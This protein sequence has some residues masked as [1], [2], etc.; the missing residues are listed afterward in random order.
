V[1][2]CGISTSRSINAQVRP[3][4]CRHACC[5]HREFARICTQNMIEKGGIDRPK[6]GSGFEVAVVQI[7][8]ARLRRTRH[9]RLDPAERPGPWWP[10]H[11]CFLIIRI[12]GGLADGDHVPGRTSAPLPAGRRMIGRHGLA[13]CHRQ[14]LVCPSLGRE[15]QP[16]S[17]AGW[18]KLWVVG[19]GPSVRVSKRFLPLAMSC[20]AD[21]GQ[22]R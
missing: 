21:H 8:Q 12:C 20:R 13:R 14:C 4:A 7:G 10:R 19:S 6:V 1:P 22:I 15:A 17:R 3:L 11:L 5:S 9:V 18:A 2:G 16:S